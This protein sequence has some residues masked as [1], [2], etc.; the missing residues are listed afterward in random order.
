MYF[1]HGKVKPSYKKKNQL[2]CVKYEPEACII[3]C[4]LTVFIIV[5]T[6]WDGRDCLFFSQQCY[7]NILCVCV[8]I[9][10]GLVFVVYPQ[11]FANMPVSQ[12]WSVIFFFML[13]CLGL[14]SEV[15]YSDNWC[16]KKK[17]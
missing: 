10:P 14:D 15:V 13:L 12:L 8:S 6:L 16:K 9:G 4:F 17:I 2:Q 7:S 1:D 3:S 5:F 11:A